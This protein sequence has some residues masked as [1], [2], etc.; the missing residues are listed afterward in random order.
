MKTAILSRLRHG[1]TGLSP[2]NDPPIVKT[3][4]YLIFL[5]QLTEYETFVDA[6]NIVVKRFNTLLKQQQ[7]Y[8][9]HHDHG[10]NGGEG[11]AEA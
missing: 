6:Y 4:D 8:N 10:G 3:V 7:S 1:K 2:E 5:G 9:R 11:G